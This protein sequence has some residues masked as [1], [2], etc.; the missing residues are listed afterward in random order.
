[1]SND[2]MTLK[3]QY[4]FIH[5]RACGIGG[6]NNG[7]PITLLTLDRSSSAPIAANN[8]AYLGSMYYDTTTNSIQCYGST[9]WGACGAAPDNIVNLNPEYAGSVLDGSGIGT[10]TADFCSNDTALSVNTSLCSTGQ[11]KNFYQWTSPQATLQTYSIYITYQLPATFKSFA[12]DNTVQ[13]TGRVDSTTNANVTYQMFNS[14]GSAVT[15]CG[16][17][18]TDVIT[19]GGGSANTWYTYGING[20][21]AT[22]CSF[23]ASNFVI[24][25]I[26]VKAKSNANAYISTLSFTTTGK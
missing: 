5:Q 13:L 12:S 16:S 3:G 18:E 7:G 4:R 26:N 20:N 15:Q 14:T 19:G 6:A 1:M 2:S 9:G 11:A 8:D 25:K 10:M 22:T 23:A 17:G 21:E 24:F